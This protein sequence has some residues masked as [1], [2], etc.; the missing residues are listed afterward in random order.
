MIESISGRDLRFIGD[1]GLHVLAT[2]L[3]VAASIHR[4]THE[5]LSINCTQ[6][7]EAFESSFQASQLAL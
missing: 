7:S 4:G 3:V 5:A 2:D 6:G 1:T